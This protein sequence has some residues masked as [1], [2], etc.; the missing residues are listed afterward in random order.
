M[1][2][3]FANETYTGTWVTVD[4]PGS[5]A[6][7]LLNGVNAGGGSFMGNATTSSFSTGG[8]GTALLKSDKGNSMKCEVR[9]DS[10][11]A[12]AAGVCRRQDGALFDIQVS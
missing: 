12:T 11:N 3:A 4:D 6:F 5:V 10:W 2:V 7:S 1:N 8:Y 9:Y